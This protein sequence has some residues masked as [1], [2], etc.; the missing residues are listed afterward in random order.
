MS[1]TVLLLAG[2]P[3]GDAHG[4]ALAAALRR[5][6]PD[7]R[8]R[9]T[10]G[11]RM[12]RAG[13][14]L[15]A[16]LDDLAVMGFVEVLP[17]LAFFSR[18]A[19]AIDRI[20][21]EDDVALVVPID[22]P[23]FNMRMARTAKRR[24]VPV[25]YYIAPQVW[26]WRPGR[27]RALAAFADQVAVVLPFEV[28]FLRGYGVA[29]EFV[30]H[31][32]LDRADEPP[33]RET[34]CRR[35]G[36]AP[37]RPLL[38]LLPGSRAQEIA[39]HLGVFTAAAESARRARPDVQPVVSRAATLPAELF[40]DVPFPVVEDAHGLLRHASAAL[41]KSGT[42]TL[43]AALEGTPSV[44]VYRT[45]ALTWAL[46]K[47]LVRVESVAL[48]NLVTGERIVPELLQE[49][50]T[51]EALS[52]EL[53]PLMDLDDPRRACQIEGLARVRSSLGAPGATQ[54]VA[55]MALDLMGAGA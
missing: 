10:G 54:R 34:F 18:L 48:P 32:L 27:A 2:E 38:A 44:V 46:A 12:A 13:V 43:E 7:I 24:G 23:G 6:A 4:A 55:R 5:A 53:L 49:R 31:P 50:A 36:L 25:L 9:G 47:R 35:W 22:Y 19:R 28:D 37:D 30:G 16:G 26:A 33:D 51:A 29:A 52:R 11:P 1:R 17:R 20:L 3:S 40:S 8:M 41:V 45:S 14:E 21:T 15:I 39:R 42:A